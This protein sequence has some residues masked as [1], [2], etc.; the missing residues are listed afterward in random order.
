MR[1]LAVLLILAMMAGCLDSDDADPEETPPPADPSVP[2]RELEA[3]TMVGQG[4]F[5]GCLGDLITCVSFQAG[6][7]SDPID[8]YWF[9][10]NQTLWLRPFDTASDGA[11]GDTDC[12]V[13][14]EDL[15]ELT[16]PGAFNQDLDPCAGEFPVDTAWLFL[17]PY[18]EPA[19][20]LE[21]HLPAVT[22]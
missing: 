20:I 10:I 18:A 11:V 22:L 4:P 17:Y 7:G 14:D 12:I 19:Q 8:G 16:D 15:N 9:E 21:V 2:Q 6:P 1:W 5:I 13:L 3:V